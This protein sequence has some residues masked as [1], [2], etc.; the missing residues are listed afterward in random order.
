MGMPPFASPF[1]PVF[2]HKRTSG[3]P[4]AESPLGSPLPRVSFFL[5]LFIVLH[6]FAALNPLIFRSFYAR[7]GSIHHDGFF[8]FPIVSGRPPPPPD[9]LILLSFDPLCFIV[10]SPFKLEVFFCLF[11]AS[12]GER[13]WSLSRGQIHLLNVLP[14]CLLFQRRF[15]LGFSEKSI[16]FAISFV[17]QDR[18]LFPFV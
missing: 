16:P 15:L 17:R 1:S 7:T 3:C 14:F 6:V 9:V 2:A 12:S 10:M 11:V 8:F 5:A 18:A 4:T 13:E